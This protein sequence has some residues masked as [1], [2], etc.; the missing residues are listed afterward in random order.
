M[1]VGL[2]FRGPPGFLRAMMASGGDDDRA[3]S[4]TIL[5]ILCIAGGGTALLAP[6][7]HQG[8]PVLAGAAGLILVAAMIC[9]ALL[10]SLLSLQNE[11]ASD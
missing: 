8:L 10:P 2:G 9:L 11:D 3:A 4:L 7:I 5:G 6:F 1:N